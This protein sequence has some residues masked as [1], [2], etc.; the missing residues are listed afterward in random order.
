MIGA[1]RDVDPE[2]YEGSLYISWHLL[3]YSPSHSDL[4]LVSQ[5]KYNMREIDN[6][7]RAFSLCTMKYFL[8]LSL[9][10]LFSVSFG[11]KGKNQPI[12]EILPLI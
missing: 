2:V 1:W 11:Q 6:N 5:Y 9:L 12:P 7:H 4:E 10:S 8:N 3:Q